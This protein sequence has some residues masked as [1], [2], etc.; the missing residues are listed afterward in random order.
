M[1][2][3]KREHHVEI[4]VERDGNDTHA[5]ASM[6]WRDAD[7]VGTGDAE[8]EDGER[9]PKRVGEELAVARALTHLTRQLFVTT[10]GDIESVT[11]ESTSVR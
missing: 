3:K 8:L 6:R 1:G 11:G 10:A 7:L 4:T 5:S 9:Y 2:H